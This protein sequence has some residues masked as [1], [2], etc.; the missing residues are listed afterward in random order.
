MF[1]KRT[2]YFT[3]CSIILVFCQHCIYVTLEN[4]FHV[5][6]LIKFGLRLANTMSKC[7]LKYWNACVRTWHASWKKAASFFA[8]RKCIGFF[9]IFWP[10]ICV[11]KPTV[12]LQQWSTTGCRKKCKNLKQNLF[13]LLYV[14]DRH[15]QLH[16]LRGY[17]S[18]IKP[19]QCY[20]KINFLF[21]YWT[22]CTIN[23][24]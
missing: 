2:L 20:K 23:I 15:G 14:Q 21:R 5:V 10:D 9:Y 11:I 6:I 24:T 16:L 13:L 7:C 18:V 22:P 17:H 4:K 8:F 1:A 19:N 12:P 3:F